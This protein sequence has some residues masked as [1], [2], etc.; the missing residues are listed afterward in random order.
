MESMKIY[1]Y[2]E[3]WAYGYEPWRYVEM[4]PIVSPAEYFKRLAEEGLHSDK[5]RGIEHEEVAL[6]DVPISWIQERIDSVVRDLE[7]LEYNK[8]RLQAE[9]R[10][11]NDFLTERSKV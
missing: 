2:R 4:S 5:F 3:V 9:R 1:K 11:W 6:A 10:I 7:R 8:Q